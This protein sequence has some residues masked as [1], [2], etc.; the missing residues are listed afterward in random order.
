MMEPAPRRCWI[1]GDPGDSD[2]HRRKRSDLVARYGSSW[3]PE[4]QPFVIRGDGS[5]RWTRIQSPNDRKNLYE[6]MLC[7]PCNNA[8]T[9]PFDQAYQKF[10]DWVLATA[11]ALHSE[12]E[13][14][15]AEIYGSVYVEQSLNLLRYFAK[16]LGCRIAAAGIEP[17]ETLRQILTDHNR[18]DTKPL[19]VTFG[20]N[21][22]W[23]RIDPSGRIIGDDFFDSWPEVTERPCFS[24]MA[25]L[26]YLE[27]FY[28]YDLEWEDGYPS[29]GE[30]MWESR[31]TVTLGR[32]D[33]LPD[34]PAASM[35]RSDFPS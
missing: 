13:I 8:R 32:H 20:I 9:K 3:T 31:R 26:G 14:D 5:S 2:E 21:E 10:S 29:G 34:E 12:E 19:V 16:S 23:H 17:P 24:W 4:Q 25:L 15:F 18:T 27:I 6:K 35:G 11:P 30:P 33:P 28:W 7:Q 22:S 1:C